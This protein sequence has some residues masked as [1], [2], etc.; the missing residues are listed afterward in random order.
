MSPNGQTVSCTTSAAST[1][2]MR[3]FCAARDL[4]VCQ[5]MSTYVNTIAAQLDPR[6]PRDRARFSCVAANETRRVDVP[7]HASVLG[8]AFQSDGAKHV[9]FEE[10]AMLQSNL[11]IFLFVHGGGVQQST[12]GHLARRQT[13]TNCGAHAAKAHRSLQNLDAGRTT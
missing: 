9:R 6:L 2:V 10:R 7:L 5:R 12:A 3:L 13:P 4:L 11:R 8:P 1:R